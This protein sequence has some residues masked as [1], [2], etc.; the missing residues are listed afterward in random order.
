[1]TTGIEGHERG[2]FVQRRTVVRVPWKGH[3]PPAFCRISRARFRAVRKAPPPVVS[4]PNC[5]G[6]RTRCLWIAT[7]C[8]DAVRYPAE[9]LAELYHR[10]WSIELFDHDIKTTLHMEVMRTQS[11]DRIQKERLMHAIAYNMIRALILQSAR[12]HAQQFGR[13]ASRARLTCWGS[14][15]RKLQPATISRANMSAGMTNCRKPCQRAES[16]APQQTRASR[17]ETTPPILSTAHLTAQPVP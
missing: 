12:A 15:C 14:G 9:K 17:Q 16:A 8:T 13:L 3:S 10:R 11:P 7:T 6:F 1:V 5:K 2:R 4:S